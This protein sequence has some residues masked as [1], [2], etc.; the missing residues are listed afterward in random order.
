MPTFHPAIRSPNSAIAHLNLGDCYRLLGRYADAKK[1]FDIALSRD[2]SLA[3]AHYDLGLMFLTAPTIPGYTADSQVST[4]IKELET[5]RTMRGPKPLPGVQDDIDDLIAR[6]KAKQAE[7]K[8]TPAAAAPA[9]T[10]PASAPPTK[11]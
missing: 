10:P 2:S 8:Q 9:A 5:Y 1:E 6:A 3:A 7:L 11:K 4:A